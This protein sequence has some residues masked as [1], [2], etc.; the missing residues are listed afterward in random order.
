MLSACP[1]FVGE[2]VVPGVGGGFTA[3]STLYN[4]V[5]RSPAVVTEGSPLPE[6]CLCAPG[7]D[8]TVA[9]PIPIQVLQRQVD[10]I[11]IRGA[12][13]GRAIIQIDG[14]PEE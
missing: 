7:Q 6:S 8:A 14:A 9:C 10:S 5:L 1:I 2:A 4:A 12:V 13:R 3:S 11:V